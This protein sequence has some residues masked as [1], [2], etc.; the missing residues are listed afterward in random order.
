MIT[1]RS[2]LRRMV[3]AMIRE[4]SPDLRG[5][6]G[7]TVRRTG[8]GFVADLPAP[9]LAKLAALPDASAAVH[10]PLGIACH[11]MAWTLHDRG[12]ARS[13]EE[14]AAMIEFAAG[15]KQHWSKAGTWLEVERGDYDLARCHLA[16]A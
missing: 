2:R 11:N 5:G 13:A 7:V 6:A 16:A 14:T 1:S 15:S 3:L 9:I 12:N 10:R 8:Q 4:H